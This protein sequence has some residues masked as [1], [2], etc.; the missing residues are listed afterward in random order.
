M[1]YFIR[2]YDAVKGA[3]YVN[4]DAIGHVYAAPSGLGFRIFGSMLAGDVDEIVV[5]LT[6]EAPTA[7][8]AWDLFFQEIDKHRS[9]AAVSFIKHDGGRVEA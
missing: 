6:P 3:G 4:L 9:N 7:A 2:S 1:A 8:L 5:P